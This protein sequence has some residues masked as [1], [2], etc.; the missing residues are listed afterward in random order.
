MF[1]LAHHVSSD[2]VG[3]RSRIRK[4]PY[5]SC[6]ENLAR[7]HPFLF[8]HSL[9]SPLMASRP[10][11]AAALSDFFTRTGLG[12]RPVSR[13]IAMIN[14]VQLQGGGEHAECCAPR[15]V[16]LNNESGTPLAVW[17]FEPGNSTRTTSH[18]LKGIIRLHSGRKRTGCRDGLVAN[19]R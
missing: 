18:R 4:A 11:L 14:C 15:N 17:R 1:S 10:A 9:L 16:S 13:Y 3:L 6:Q 19:G 2:S 8:I 5:P 7:T 12:A